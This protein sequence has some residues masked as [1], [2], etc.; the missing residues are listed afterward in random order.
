MN[1]FSSGW[2]QRMADKAGNAPIPRIQSLFG[3]LQDWID[4]PGMRQPLQ[5]ALLDE[6]GRQALEIYLRQLVKASGA[7]HPEM[8]SSQLHM[9]LLGALSE[10]IRHPGSQALAHAGQAALLLINA[11]MPERRS[12]RGSYAVAASMVLIA[13]G[14]A[15]LLTRHQPEPLVVPHMPKIAAVPAVASNPDRMAALYHLHEQIQVADCSYPQA[16][17]LAPEQR[18]PF[19]EN[20]VNGDVGKLKPELVVMVSQLYQ[21]VNCYYPPAAMQL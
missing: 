1:I 8:V 11:Q 12:S 9:L 5:D 7:T 15:L 16:L 17:M 13:G 20:V 6:I 4:A 19:M 3:I 18:A 21:R 14:L 2:L 10:E